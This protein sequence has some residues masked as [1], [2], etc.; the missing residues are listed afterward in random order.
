[1]PT[2][3]LRHIAN[4]FPGKNDEL[5]A[6]ALAQLQQKQKTWPGIDRYARMLKYMEKRSPKTP[7]PEP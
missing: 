2:N 5:R 6:D 1:L 4:C 3:I 7:E